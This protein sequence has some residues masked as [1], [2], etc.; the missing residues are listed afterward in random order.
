[1]E[2]QL[3]REDFR[4]RQAVLGFSGW[5]DAGK[6]IQLT[7]DQM[8]ASLRCEPV[9]VLDMDGFWHTELTRP[10]V[11]V[12]QGQIQSLD[13]PAW[14]F[15]LC[16]RPSMEPVLVGMGPEPGCHWRLFSKELIELLKKQG[17]E[18]VLLLG[19]LFDQVLHD[20]ILIS[21]V[22][23]D[24]LGFNR[25]HELGCHLVEYTGAS[26]IHAAIMEAAATSNMHC[27]S[28]WAHLPFYL[29]GP[30]ERI[31]ARFLQILGALLN[32]EFDTTALLESWKRRQRE[33]EDSIQQDP[34]LL[35]M[36]ESIKK[37]DSASRSTS[38]SSKVVRLDEFLRKRPRPPADEQ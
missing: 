31:V 28:F 22:V 34:D 2:F 16:G 29:D 3:F 17:C 13:W 8:K 1:M 26:A 12:H 4:A 38:R 33:I 10:R 15:F 14:R 30:H 25:V 20:E 35:S 24:V 23:Q 18:E 19:S 21:C 11:T 6:T 7:L 37:E 5:P 27:M 36:L 9:A 32:L